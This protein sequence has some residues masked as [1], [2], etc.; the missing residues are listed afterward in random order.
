MH[1]TRP[2]FVRVSTALALGAALFVGCS[3]RGEAPQ[4][5]PEQ[6]RAPAAQPAPVARP[7]R[8]APTSPDQR[9]ALAP[10]PTIAELPAAPAGDRP[11][12]AYDEEDAPS[13]E[14]VTIDL[15]GAPSLGAVDAPVTLVVFSDFQCPFCAKAVRTLDALEDRYGSSLRI[16][17]KNL[18]LPFHDRAPAAARAALAAAEQG[19]FWEYHDALFAAQHDHHETTYE[20]HAKALG[21]DVGR[22]RSALDDSRLAARVDA[23]AA[24]AKRLGVRGTPTFF[25]NGRKIIGAQPVSTFTPVIDAELAALGKPIP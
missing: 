17:F 4:P 3:Q 15:A 1:T 19:R 16:V 11:S 13:E 2:S 9:V 14:R 20:E 5:E 25:V 12:C 10:A 21:L 24:E 7:K 6:L 8:V 18:P 23:D 22:F